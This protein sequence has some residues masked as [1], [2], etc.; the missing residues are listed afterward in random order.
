MLTNWRGMLLRSMSFVSK[1]LL[2]HSTAVVIIFSVLVQMVFVGTFLDN[3]VISSYAPTATDAAD[4]KSRA[5]LWQSQGFG[6]AFND[7]SR[8]PGYPFALYISQVVFFNYSNLII[9]ILQLVLVAISAGIIKLVLEKYVPRELAVLGGA[10]FGLLPIWHFVPILI[11]E[12]FIAVIATVSIYLLTKLHDGVL[13]R[14]IILCLSLCVTMATYIKPNNFLLIIPIF[15]FLLFSKNSNPIKSISKIFTIV[16][17]L[18]LPWLVFAN[19]AQPGFLGLTTGS[20]VN[21]YTG[22]GMILEYNQGFLSR[23]AIKWRVDPKNNITDSI[24]NTGSLTPAEMNSVYSQKSI[25][26]WKKRFGRQLGFGI[27]KVKFAFS[28]SSD[29]KF[30]SLIGFFN[31]VAFT[32]GLI[33]LKFRDLRSWGGALLL[34]TVTL[35]L[36]AIVFQADRRFVVTIFFPFAAVCLGLAFGKITKRIS[37]V[38]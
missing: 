33:L 32:A 13:T 12:T 38:S 6:A 16:L 15:G 30:E 21:A 2:G 14:N 27:D 28:V 4:Y 18:L 19:T 7:A 11:G 35:A 17:L 25:E 22:T 20:G 5:L 9:R 3:S 26:I 10:L 29:S 1:I 36:Q 37:P 34:L 31:L 24:Q 23:S 8:M